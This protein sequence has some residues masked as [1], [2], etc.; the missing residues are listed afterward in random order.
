MSRENDKIFLG[1]GGIARYLGISV[2]TVRARIKRR[3]W[4]CLPEG[5]FKTS[6]RAHAE[7]RCPEE[8]VILFRNRL[9]KGGAA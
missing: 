4:S 2:E 6:P 7:W 5:M 1:T 3:Q 8:N 9:M